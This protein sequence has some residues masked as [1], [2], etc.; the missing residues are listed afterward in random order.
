MRKHDERSSSGDE[1]DERGDGAPEPDFS[2][3]SFEIILARNI[4]GG[5]RRYRGT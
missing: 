5:T 2:L 1:P 3:F 4:I